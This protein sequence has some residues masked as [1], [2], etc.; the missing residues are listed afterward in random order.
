MVGFKEEVMYIIGVYGLQE[1][2]SKTIKVLLDH[3][4]VNSVL[5]PYQFGKQ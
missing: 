4:T 5:N 2:L 3:L 1:H